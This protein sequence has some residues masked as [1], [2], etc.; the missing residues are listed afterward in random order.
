MKPKPAS[1]KPIHCANCNTDE[2]C[3]DHCRCGATY[4]AICA[5]EGCVDTSCDE[6]K[7]GRR[8]AC[9]YDIVIDNLCTE[10]NRRASA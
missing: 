10:A 8:P 1:M 6:C 2:G 3:T 5:K 7:D 9:G 4:C